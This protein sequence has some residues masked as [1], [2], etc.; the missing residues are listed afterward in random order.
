[1]GLPSPPARLPPGRERGAKGGAR[2]VQPRA[3]AL[4]YSMPPLTGLRK[5]GAH[6]NS[7]A[8]KGKQHGVYRVC[9]DRARKAWYVWGTFD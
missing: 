1:M 4:G 6:S 7:E 3:Y 5:T 9:Y 8:E 2:A